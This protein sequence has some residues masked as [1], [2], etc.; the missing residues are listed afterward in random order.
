MAL[1]VQLLFELLLKHSA[2]MWL[3]KF[4]W[5]LFIQGPS[6]LISSIITEV[7]G[8]PKPCYYVI[9]ENKLSIQKKQKMWKEQEWKSNNRKE[10]VQ[11]GRVL[12]IADI[13]ERWGE[14]KVRS[15]PFPQISRSWGGGWSLEWGRHRVKWGNHL[16]SAIASLDLT[17]L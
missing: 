7:M 14:E 15:T 17:L 2:S 16:G 3:I 4:L 5:I 6:I 9:S 8:Y 1:S 12:I 10:Q 11:Q 13:T